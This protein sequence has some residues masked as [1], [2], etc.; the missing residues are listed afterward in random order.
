MT[1]HH[2]TLEDVSSSIV[3]FINLAAG[4]GKFMVAVWSVDD[5]E[6]LNLSRSTWH[7]P[8][9]MFKE[10]VEKL[11]K[12][13]EKES[14]V[15]EATPPSLPS[16]EIIQGIHLPG[17]GNVPVSSEV[18]EETASG[19]EPIEDVELGELKAIPMKDHFIEGEKETSNETSD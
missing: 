11:Y 4:T 1:K 9:D 14:E 5:K 6:Q 12:D 18:V 13:L 15:D 2:S 19:I 3:N 7:F 17:F 10:S 16:A 8:K